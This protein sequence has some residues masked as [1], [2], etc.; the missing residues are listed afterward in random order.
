MV[1]TADHLLWECNESKKIWSLYNE[2]MRELNFTKSIINK[3]EDIYRTESLDPLSSIKMKIVQ[4][5]IQIERPRNWT[6]SRIYQIIDQIRSIEL[7]NAI[8]K[9]ETEIVNR[10]WRDFQGII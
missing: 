8:A 7:F 9:N 2:T 10:K 3:C 4:E 6:K 5:F 1:E